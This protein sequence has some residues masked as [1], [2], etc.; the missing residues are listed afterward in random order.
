M[1]APRRRMTESPIRRLR[2]GPFEFDESDARLTRAGE[3]VALAPKAFEVLG[4]LL[5]RPGQLVTKDAL[6]DAVW[7]HRHVSDSV[8]KTT[9]SE[10]RGAL[11]D[12]ARNPRWVETAA[13]RGYRFIGALEEAQAPPRAPGRP[14]G[15]AA[16]TPTPPTPALA[17]GAADP[18]SAGIIGRDAALA[19]LRE[20]WDDAATA[21]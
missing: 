3:A 7:G 2:F 5:L 14:Q 10:L 1:A 17:R 19:R 8:L 9:V 12:D 4:V 21:G 18:E 16:P 6:L 20:A 11:G 13:R 15:A